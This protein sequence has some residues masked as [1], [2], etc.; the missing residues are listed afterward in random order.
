MQL[1]E[2]IKS[3]GL[4]QYEAAERLGISVFSL[5]RICTGHS[6]PTL[7][8]VWKIETVTRR[9]VTLRDFIDLARSHAPKTKAAAAVLDTINA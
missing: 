9:K 2:W 3:K 6:N 8:Q 5:N 4:K 1:N 7:E